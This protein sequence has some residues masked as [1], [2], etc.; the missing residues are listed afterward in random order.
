MLELQKYR[1]CFMAGCFAAGG[2]FFGKMPS[3]LD[4]MDFEII[5]WHKAFTIIKYFPIVLMII[6]NVLNWRYFLKAL[7]LTEQTLTA[8]VLTSAS[9]YVV[10]F[11]LAS[12]IYK[13]PITWLSTVGTS[14]IVLGLWFLCDDT[15]K[16]VKSSK[17]K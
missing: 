10:S 9:N 8:T 7:Q 5:H 2:S 4:N 12:L 14:L 13:E 11:L 6:C 16:T 3:F 1:Y 15:N 17:D